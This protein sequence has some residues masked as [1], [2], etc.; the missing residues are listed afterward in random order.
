MSASEKKLLSGAAKV[1]PSLDPASSY[2]S[3]A[4]AA[5]PPSSSA[6][7]HAESLGMPSLLSGLV[8]LAV[9]VMAECVEVEE[10]MR[11]EM[12]AQVSPAPP[13]LVDLMDFE[14]VLCTGS[15]VVDVVVMVGFD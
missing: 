1:G 6:S 10:A 4:G 2:L 13:A 15:V 11:E 3:N 5:T 7:C 9:R 14:C 12:R 8:E